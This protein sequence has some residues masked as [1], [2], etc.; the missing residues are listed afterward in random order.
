[1][2]VARG[3]SAN[4]VSL[5]GLGIGAFAAI[6]FANWAD[7]VFAVAGLLLSIG[8]LIAD[9]LDGMIARA[10]GTA[11]ALGRF[12]DGLCDHGVFILI[13]IALAWSIGT[14]DAW[15]L[16]AAAGGAHALQ[17]NL[18]ESER[19]RF[20]RR[21]KGMTRQPQA[22]GGNLLVRCYDRVSLIVEKPAKRFDETL[23][24]HA[25]PLELGQTYGACVTKP[26]RL[27]SLLS[28]NVRVWAIFVACLAQNP[29]L[30][31]WFELLPLTAILVI[32]VYW[33]R[34]L[35]GRLIRS[36]ATACGS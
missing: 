8:W 34:R 1:M 20:H 11:S 9:G 10:T 18:Y 31:W 24:S 12:L 22:E 35:E 19:A 15:G 30:F 25:R 23:R 2:F 16:A 13:Y 27:L 7:P 6:A 21:C 14:G 36:A 28:A 32:G 3:I 5:A 26:L 4:S 33:H 29:R 17:S